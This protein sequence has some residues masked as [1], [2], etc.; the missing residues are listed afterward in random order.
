M[1]ATPEIAEPEIDERILPDLNPS[2]EDDTDYS[3]SGPYVVILYNDD[4]HD[5]D[6]VRRAATKGDG[7]QHRAMR[8]HHDRSAHAGTGYRLHQ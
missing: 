7:L 1:P 5:M 6:E 8:A 4:H 2:I 3:D